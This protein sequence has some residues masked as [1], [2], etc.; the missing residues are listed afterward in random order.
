MEEI[1]LI[2]LELTLE[3]VD[4]IF[5]SLGQRPFQDVFE[6]IGKI[7]QQVNSQLQTDVDIEEEK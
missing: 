4:I 5:N 2:H 6:I 1:Q 3:E 7:N